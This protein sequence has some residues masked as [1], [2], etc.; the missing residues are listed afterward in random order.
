MIRLNN[1]LLIPV[2]YGLEELP[3]HFV[4]QGVEV[5]F[6]Y[7]SNERCPIYLSR[8]TTCINDTGVHL[9][10]RIS[11]RSFEK[12][13]N[14][15]NG[16]L[17]GLGETD[18]LKNQKSKISWHCPLKVFI[19]YLSGIMVLHVFLLYLYSMMTLNAFTSLPF[20]DLRSISLSLSSMARKVST[21]PVQH[22]VEG[23]D[24]VLGLPV[25]GVED[26]HHKPWQKVYSQLDHFL[27]IY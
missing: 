9:E 20:P 17:M 21:L 12:I 19:I 26:Q 1:F 8:C 6:L 15:S 25:P 18:P 4:K 2:Q 22:G 27:L 5:S 10:L 14:G 11:P 13:Q 3:P 16:I 24:G 7:Q 23:L